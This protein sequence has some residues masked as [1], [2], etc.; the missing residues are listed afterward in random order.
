[1]ANKVQLKRSA[2]AGKIPTTTDLD[3]GE[4]AINTYDGKAYIKK[5]VGGVE[6][7][8]PLGGAGSGDVT[9]PA[10]ATDNAIARFDGTTGKIIQNSSATIDDSGNLSAVSQISTGTEAN[11]IPVGTTAQRPASPAVGH[12]R[13]NTTEAKYEV[14]TSTGWAYLSTVAYLVPVEY[15]VIAGGGGGRS[16]SSG[17][18][19]YGMGGAGAGGY[20]SSIAGESSG[21]GAS[22]E[23]AFSATP[24]TAYTVTIG[25][26]GPNTNNGSNSVF[27]TITSTGGG[28]YASGGSGGGGDFNGGATSG[29]AGQGYS[30]AGGTSNQGGGG[31]G[32]G[33][34]GGFQ[35]GGAGVSSSVTGTSVAR[36]GGGGGGNP[37]GSGGSASA[38]GGAGGSGTQNGTAGTANTGG[39][40]GGGSIAG[41]G[42]VVGGAGGS[43]VVILKYSSSITPTIS[44]GLTHSTATVGANK[45]TTFTA[46]TGTITF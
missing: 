8:V 3:L 32:A 29:T 18:G 14:Y 21:G 36:A 28:A 30:G 46:G 42:A 19:S 13:Y 44:A 9:G 40:G 5:N 16:V 4:I 37:F 34:A 35:G 11:K 23:S 12:I 7:I 22:A 6:S 10:S 26:G 15:L 33:G 1:M 38:G 45:V 43:G 41:S 20:R 25:A 17:G 2:V 39:G 31:G 24:G 27:A